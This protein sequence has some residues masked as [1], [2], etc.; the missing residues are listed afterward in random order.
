MSSSEVI[1]EPRPDGVVVV[2]HG[3]RPA[4]HHLGL[5]FA[6]TPDDK[7]QK[8]KNT[9]TS[10]I[11]KDDGTCR[12]VTD[13]FELCSINS[14]RTVPGTVDWW[15]HDGNDFDEPAIA[16]EADGGQGTFRVG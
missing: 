10:A 6:F 1:I 9:G 4:G 3:L 8:G 11:V 7:A 12:A 13:T 14:D 5:S 2:G 16:S 15:W